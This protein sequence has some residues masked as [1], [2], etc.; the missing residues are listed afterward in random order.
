MSE[1]DHEVVTPGTPPTDQTRVRAMLVGAP[2]AGTTSLYRYIVQHPGIV[3]HAQREMTYFFSDEEFARGYATSC[4]KY[5]PDAIGEKAVFVGKHVF[6]MYRPEAVARLNEHNPDGHLFV[7]LRDPARRAYS[8]FWYARRRGWDPANSFDEAIRREQEQPPRE[9]SWL[10][11]RD[12]MHLH[13]GI[14]EPHIRRLGD[15]FGEDRVHVFLNDD[16]AQDP[17][18]LCRRVYESI[19]LDTGFVPDL[20][21]VHNAAAEARSQVVA[22][23]VAGVLKS[24]GRIKRTARRFIPHGLARRAR[25]ALLRI[26]EKPFIPPPMHEDTRKRLIDYYAPHNEALSQLIGRDLSAWS[27]P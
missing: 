7:L 15:I 1:P 19:G 3:S 17:A 16:L 6:A 12:R 22:R 2:K 13:V 21:R 8:S 20:A 10:E 14:Y 24:R 4:E 9:E 23:S 27:T 26:N 25:H 5:L 11:D 18:G